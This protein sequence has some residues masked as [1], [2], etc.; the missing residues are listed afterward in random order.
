MPAVSSEIEGHPGL[1]PHL[2]FISS[3][4]HSDSRKEKQYRMGHL[5]SIG[6]RYAQ[7]ISRVGFKLDLAPLRINVG[8]E[9]TSP[10]LRRLAKNQTTTHAQRTD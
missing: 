7:H 3:A 9:F 6:I 1:P 2:H 10:H 5:Y 4:Y 8:P